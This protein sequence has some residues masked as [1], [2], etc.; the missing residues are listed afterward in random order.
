MKLQE[1]CDNL[2]FN[3]LKE[4]GTIIQCI[5]EVSCQSFGLIVGIGEI[6]EVTSSNDNMRLCTETFQIFKEEG[7]SNFMKLEKY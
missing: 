1:I 6:H 4:P 3:A 5:K 7:V 2:H